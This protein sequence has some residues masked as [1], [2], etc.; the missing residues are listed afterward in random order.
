MTVVVGADARNDQRRRVGRGVLLFDNYQA[1]ERRKPGASCEPRAPSFAAK[2]LVRAIAV[3]ASPENRRAARNWCRLGGGRREC[4]AHEG[5]LGAM[6]GEFVDLAV[7]KLDRA[8]ELRRR[9]QLEATLAQPAVC[10]EAGMRGKPARDRR[11]IDGVA[12]TRGQAAAGFFESIAAIVC[13]ER[14][15]DFVER[16]GLVAQSARAGRESAAARP[17]AIQPDRFELLGAAA[18]RAMLRLLQAGQRSGGLMGDLG[19]AAA[20]SVE[21]VMRSL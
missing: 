17:A 13:R 11:R 2:K 19:F 16:I 8:D 7:I 3:C 12:V 10:R 6:K 14:I 4:R 20:C 5:E 21:R 18:P 1:V 15:K 9:E